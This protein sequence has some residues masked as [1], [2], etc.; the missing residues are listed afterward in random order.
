MKVEPEAVELPASRDPFDQMV[1]IVGKDGSHNVC[2]RVEPLCSNLRSVLAPR[3]VVD[4]ATI[5]GNLPVER[6]ECVE[7]GPV[8]DPALPDLDGFLGVEI[9]RLGSAG[10]GRRAIVAVVDGGHC[11]M[12]RLTGGILEVRVLGEM[13]LDQVVQLH[14][15]W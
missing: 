2:I 14:E 12:N 10:V 9:S 13:S 6:E 15:G 4:S 8:V 11:E 5:V 1:E 3:R 7:L